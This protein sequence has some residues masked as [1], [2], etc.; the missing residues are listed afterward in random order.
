MEINLPV[1]LLRDSYHSENKL[2]H[3]YTPTIHTCVNET[4]FSLGIEIFFQKEQFKYK[5]STWS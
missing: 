1:T 5:W 2:S 3:T 4:R